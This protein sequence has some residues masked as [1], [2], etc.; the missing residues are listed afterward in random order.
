MA[1]RT[2][3]RRGGL[4]LR[5]ATLS[6]LVL[7]SALAPNSALALAPAR[8][9]S[10]YV[11]QVFQ[12][13]DGLPQSSVY[14]T[15][16]D[17]EGFLWVGTQEGLA[18]FDGREFR[19]F[20]R[21]SNP[22]LERTLVH[23]LALD[24][25]GA[26]WIGSEGGLFRFQGGNLESVPF[27]QVDSN[28]TIN[29][30]LLS[31]P[32]NLWVSTNEGLFRIL[33][34]RVVP[35]LRGA[36]SQRLAVGKLVQDATGRIW[37]GS[38]RGLFYVEGDHLHK[39]PFGNARNEGRVIGLEL[40]PDGSL[41]FAAPGGIGRVR[42]GRLEYPLDLP[43]IPP[44]SVHCIHVDPMGTAWLGTDNGLFRVVGRQVA[45]LNLDNGLPANLVLSIQTDRDGNLW[46]GTDGGGLVRLSDGPIIPWGPPEKL[47][48]KDLFSIAEDRDGALWI[49]TS[50]SKVIRFFQGQSQVFTKK[51]GLPDL[52]FS[53][54]TPDLS[55]GR[56]WLAGVRQTVLCRWEAN[57]CE[58]LGQNGELGG[59]GIGSL[60]ARPNGDLLV[61]TTEGKLF[62]VSEGKVRPIPGPPIP[63]PGIS[64]L[65]E[66]RDGT[67]WIGAYENGLY[68][69]KEVGK[70]GFE[71]VPGLTSLRIGALYLDE[72]ESAWI[73]TTDG[74]LL[75]V[76]NNQ[77]TDLGSIVALPSNMVLAI[78]SDPEGW[79]WFSTN[80]GLMR[81]KAQEV[82]EYAAGRTREIHFSSY[83]LEDGL[84]SIECN[85]GLV[86]S[87]IRTRTNRLLFPTLQGIA[88][89]DWRRADRAFPAVP[90]FL[91]G[92]L[93]DRRP[94]DITDGIQIPPGAREVEF[95]F[96]GIQL[97]T[98]GKLRFR[99]KLEGFDLDWVDARTRREAFYTN[100]PPGKLHFRVQA[101]VD[102]G[103]WEGREASFR[104][105]LEPHFYETRPFFFLVGGTIAALTFTGYRIRVR[106][107]R[108]TRK[109]LELRIKERTAEVVLQ[110][111]A[112]VQANREL[113]DARDASEAAN[114]AK[115]DFLATMS[116][117]IR[118]PMNGVI[119][120]ADLV[121]ASKL[122]PE[123]R[124]QMEL[125]KISAR[126]LLSLLNN[127][128]D[129]SKI[130]AGKMELDPIEFPL[131]KTIDEVTKMLAPRAASQRLEFLV[132]I[133][134]VVPDRLVGDAGRLRQVLVNLL[135]N[136]LK[137]TRTG[138]VVLRIGLC[139]ESVDSAELEFTVLDTGIGIPPEKQQ[140]IFDAFTQAD[141]STTRHFGGT[142]LGLTISQ[143]LI[144]LLGGHLKVES[145]E[146][147]GS[148]FSFSA[149][150]ERCPARPRGHLPNEIAALAGRKALVVEGNETSRICLIEEL[151]S[152][153]MTTT[154][155][156]TSG[157]GLAALE[158]AADQRRPFD[159]I[160]LASRLHPENAGGTALLRR[161]PR[162]RNTALI[163]LDSPG[164]PAPP[165]HRSVPLASHHLLKPF[166]E[167]DLA[168]VL[169]H[170]AGLTVS[171]PFPEESG[172]ETGKQRAGLSLRVLV[173]E[174]H[175]INQKLITRLL[176][177]E[178][179]LV[180]L[181][182][183]GRQAV[184]L[185]ANGQFDLA[186]MDIQMPEMD[187]FAATREIRRLEAQSGHHLPIIALTARAMPQDRE[188]CLVA[189][190]DGFTAKPIQSR[191]LLR[192][193]VKLVESNSST[194]LI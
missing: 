89:I 171:S 75:R 178:G 95:H 20:D 23:T 124:E 104:F 15:I 123:Q 49:A 58:V 13:A 156:A 179:H 29:G 153:E 131:R 28:Q 120:M 8:Q 109:M 11:R 85:G 32:N 133:A 24:P 98:P 12:I 91:D 175:P 138:E 102:Q 180:T 130:E 128:L 69:I 37:A 119:R 141:G 106:A 143:R 174:D 150:F 88:E 46:V 35:F 56:I 132:H 10:Q 4:T 116:H 114:R 26:L 145:R 96:G 19:V 87:A 82:E 42:E 169:L 191:E 73:G 43:E 146:T 159:I 78:L 125:L 64:A 52:P 68:R 193:M 140:L 137:F 53:I 76:K 144:Q 59:G 172:E 164:N 2:D 186:L 105:T 122:E 112:L 188:E 121:L 45:N 7:L 94:I 173:A 36:D 113:M 86:P 154:A 165:D 3:S 170:S 57:N 136:A 25:A 118:T 21:R 126:S 183:D 115:S 79:I 18:R 30:L 161:D 152:F 187:G 62:L 34:N 55:S 189:G 84:R 16:Q 61:G 39:Y 97:T 135:G 194:T 111:E 81:I 33:Q 54:V 74:K 177:R 70:P 184:E 108:R 40:A 139:S 22:K 162:V 51:N 100:L 166:S 117:E 142:G 168:Q 148:R 38:N 48:A 27:S 110:K 182:P 1:T 41:W 47:A 66:Q 44:E 185:A 134:P 63:F 167:M 50:E 14:S 5:T 151:E 155:A 147:V 93:I 127:L 181:A 60:L 99:Y 107:F 103:P 17:A 65:A 190:M 77:I 101:R 157:E 90:A 80:R 83:D 92:V 149:R 158:A 192:L 163:L 6:A 71:P 9:L 31:S 72:Q 67:L 129:L 176:E 160:F